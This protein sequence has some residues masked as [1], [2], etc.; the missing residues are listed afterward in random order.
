MA[1]SVLSSPTS[2]SVLENN[3]TGWSSFQCKN[4]DDNKI[5][6]DLRAIRDH[7]VLAKI[8]KKNLDAEFTNLHELSA[9][10]SMIDNEAPMVTFG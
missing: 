2:L 8:S 1:M 9:C 6:C 7:P 4:H 10:R 3:K 5:E